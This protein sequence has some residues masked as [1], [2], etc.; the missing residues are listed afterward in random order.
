[1][2]MEFSFG[3]IEAVCAAQNRIASDKRVAFMGRLK[4]LQKH[5]IIAPDR[6]PGRGKAGT[7]SFTDLMRF[8][9][10][11]ELMQCGL[12][13]QMAARMVNG[14][15]SG[16]RNTI[17]AATYTDEELEEWQEMPFG[18]NT[19][20]WY[21]MLTPEALREMTE[22]GF[23]KWDHMEAILPV[24]V[25]DVAELLA[26]D[27]EIGVF[28]EGS[29]MIVLHGTKIARATLFLVE[30]QFRY[31]KREALREEIQSDF[32]RLSKALEFDPLGSGIE[33][34]AKI[35]FKDTVETV[36]S[37]ME[38]EAFRARYHPSETVLERQAKR[39]VEKLQPHHLA[40]IRAEDFK[41]ETTP[42]LKAMNFLMLQGLIV[43]EME[44]DSLKLELSPLGQFVQRLAADM[45]A[46]PNAIKDWR[47]RCNAEIDQYVQRKIDRLLASDPDNPEDDEALEHWARFGGKSPLSEKRQR[48]IARRFVSGVREELKDDSE[49]LDEF[50]GAVSRL[51]NRNG[52][53]QE[54]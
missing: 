37:N 9:V 22:E 53:N 43:P 8:V 30:H 25:T 12:M 50:H 48:E 31:A 7:Y 5:D 36:M 10:A 3:Q 15:W 4:Q 21:W 44:G 40:Y 26:S 49:A 45:P 16:L 18:P 29:R 6:R 19:A 1:M 28:G 47:R 38:M 39:A 51:G 20:D 42:D 46:D 24:P 41:G 52:D 14:S 2:R 11:V 33:E 34:E 27:R 17:Y 13:P 32:D 54:A 23:G 35:R